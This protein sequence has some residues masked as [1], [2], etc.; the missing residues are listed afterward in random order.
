MAIESAVGGQLFCWR[1][2]DK[3]VIL[4]ALL[5]LVL[6][7]AAAVRVRAAL[8]PDE[9][10]GLA[11]EY[12]DSSDKADRDQLLN[13][14]R[15]SSS[16]DTKGLGRFALGMGDHKAENYAQ[17]AEELEKATGEMAELRDY[18]RYYQA[19][20]LSSA[21]QHR[22]AAESLAGFQKSFPE[23]LLVPK[24]LSGSGGIPAPER[25]KSPSKKST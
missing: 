23:S 4:A 24:A 12:L 9:L 8:I 17:A 16:R 22:E 13:Y 5:L 11:H 7:P 10:Q 25:A 15:K 21:E 1:H 3:R 14:I 20:S 18:A 6:L 19:R 2:I